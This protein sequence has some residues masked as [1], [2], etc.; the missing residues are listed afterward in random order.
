MH[1]N[2]ATHPVSLASGRPL[3]PGE[4]GKADLRDP[5]DQAL[6]DAGHLIQVDESKSETK[7]GEAK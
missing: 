7:K 6:M 5:H 2:R 4:E 1:R 3:A